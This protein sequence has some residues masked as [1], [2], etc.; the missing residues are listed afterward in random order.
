MK[1]LLSW[2]IMMLLLGCTTIPNYNIDKETH[3]ATA[4][5]SRVRFIVLHYTAGEDQVSINALT[6]PHV[7]SHYLIT[8]RMSD[9]IYKMVP[10][11]KRAWHAGI[12]EY[13][14]R[15]NLNDSS[16]GIEI[17]NKGY[18]VDGEKRTFYVYREGQVQKTAHLLADLI[19][20]YDID[21][22]RIV[23]HS[24]ISPD[25]KHDPGP[26]FPWERL[27]T[28]YGIGA[29]YDKVNY[30]KDVSIE[31]YEALSIEEVQKLFRNYGY[32]MRVNGEWT[33]YN[34]KVVRA[35]QMHFRP[36]NYS[37]EMD[38]ETYAIIKSLNKKYVKN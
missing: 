9:P 20:R 24:D 36:N 4:Y 17:V 14:G 34:I 3:I 15:T 38:L 26:F 22:T 8:S 2:L 30:M 29:W 23:G 27:Y 18:T 12:S 33:E 10:E 37:G 28:E 19:E 13:Q 32:A 16:I 11:H 1:I 5:N 25:R 31:E 21:P 35:F 6:G 7:S